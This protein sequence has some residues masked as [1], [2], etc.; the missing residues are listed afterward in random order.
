VGNAILVADQVLNPITPNLSPQALAPF[1]GL[2]NYLNGLLRLR[3]L[4]GIDVV[5]PAHAQPIPSLGARIDEIL[6]HHQERLAQVQ[7]ACTKPR[8]L[9]E[10]SE[11]L[12]GRVD[13]YNV[14]LALTEAGAHVEYLHQYG[15]LRIAN[16][17]QVAAQRDPVIEYVTD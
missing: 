9:K 13:G 12:Y 1:N 3:A 6:E 16:L 4:D 11:I 17:Q 5:L 2:E 14:I 15:K 8:T 10:L 7:D